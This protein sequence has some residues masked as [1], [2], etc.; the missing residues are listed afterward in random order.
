[1]NVPATHS[2]LP[3]D[4]SRQRLAQLSDVARQLLDRARAAGAD[5]LRVVL[6]RRND[7]IHLRIEDDGR[8]R[9][10][11]R[12]GNGLTGMRE[13][14]EERGGRIAF[15]RNDNGALCINAELPA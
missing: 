7:E 6:S 8:L 13:R 3:A 9:G 12:E 10:D 1:M 4:D 2:P 14:I 5:A 11:L 15:A